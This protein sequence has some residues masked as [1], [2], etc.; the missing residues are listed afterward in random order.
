MNKDTL[1]QV[2]VVLI[3]IITIVMNIL[4]NALPLNGQGTGEISDRFDI[5]FVPAGYVFSIWGLIYIGLIAYTI[6]QALPA[7]KTN[8]RLRATG[9]P[10]V[11]ANAA[12]IV[13][14]FLWHYNQFPAT[15]LA[16]LTLLVTL[17][18]SYLQLGIGKI[19]VS[20]G[21]T[22]AVRVPFSI[23]LGWISVATIAN[24]TQVLYYLGWNG[25]P[26]TPEI[27][28]AI[29]LAVA[30]V[31]TAAMLVIRRDVAYAGVVIWAA[32]GIAAAQA[33]SQLVVIAAWTVTAVIALLVA[34]T[35]FKVLPKKVQS[36]QA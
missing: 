32:I 24:V 34:L 25:A 23:Y 18:Y 14:L 11:I 22:W 10:Y 21:E 33:D 17:I 27:W 13:W 2:A 1:R 29:M 6:Y 31:V 4:A 36:A 7:Q 12:N 16:M 5:R 9:W 26:L 3:T 28:A 8:P 15:L 30:A 35:V 20:R 19:N